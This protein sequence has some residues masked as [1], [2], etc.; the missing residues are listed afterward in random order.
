[1]HV[2]RLHEYVLGLLETP[3]LAKGNLAIGEVN[4]FIVHIHN[5][6]RTNTF[7][8]SVM[9]QLMDSAAFRLMSVYFARTETARIHPIDNHLTTNWDVVTNL[10]CALVLRSSHIVSPVSNSYSTHYPP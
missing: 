4:K 6:I 2:D 1:M 9:T 10:T 3:K 5:L 8:D 7:D